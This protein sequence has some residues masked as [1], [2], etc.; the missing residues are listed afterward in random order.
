[1]IKLADINYVQI[2]VPLHLTNKLQVQTDKQKKEDYFFLSRDRGKLLIGVLG[3]V[4]I[5]YYVIVVCLFEM[6][7]RYISQE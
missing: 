2:C 3:I 6:N 7:F 4:L 1:M 5:D